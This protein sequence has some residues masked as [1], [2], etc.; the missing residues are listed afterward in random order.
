MAI[1]FPSNPNTGRIHTDGSKRWV[2]SGKSWDRVTS[3]DG[4]TTPTI[5]QGGSS[6]TGS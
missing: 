3:V 1:N 5:V 2:W 4:S 6:D